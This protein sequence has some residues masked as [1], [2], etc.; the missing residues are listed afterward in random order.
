MARLAE[1]AAA[2]AD[3]IRE[4]CSGSKTTDNAIGSDGLLIDPATNPD[5]INSGTPEAST[6][7]RNPTVQ[8]MI[9]E[10]TVIQLASGS[11][12]P[13]YGGGPPALFADLSDRYR[14][15]FRAHMMEARPVLRLPAPTP[16]PNV[17]A[18]IESLGT[19]TGEAFSLSVFNESGSPASLS[20]AGIV[21]EPL[22]KKAQEAV[23]K[24]LGKL[25]SKNPVTAR[26]SGYCLEFL[27]QPPDAGMFFRVASKELQEQFQPMRNILQSSRALHDA[28]ALSPDSEPKQ[29]FHSIR[30]WALWTLEQKFDQGSF[31]DAFV[32]RTKK[33][34]AAADQDWTNQIEG[35]VRGLV[36]NR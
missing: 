22:K 10:F 17:R 35:A 11:G 1:L 3:C 16:A 19:S 34:F 29:Y 25:A 20:G 7:G 13:A 32:D 5:L 4:L 33:N 36:P 18:F 8:L 9:V 6:G 15:P 23:R 28:G 30:Q 21:V 26:V 24:E 27:R 2:L 14:Q 12:E 31:E